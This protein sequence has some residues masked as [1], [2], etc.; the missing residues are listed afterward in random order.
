LTSFS[1]TSKTIQ[2]VTCCSSSVRTNLKVEGVHTSPGAGKNYVVLLHF[3]SLQMQLV[4]LVSAFVMISTIWSI[5]CLL[6]FYSRCPPP[7]SS[8]L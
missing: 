1:T 5:S 4:V 3:L 2:M 8:H 7:V 6:F